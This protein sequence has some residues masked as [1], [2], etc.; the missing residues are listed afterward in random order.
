MP[1]FGLGQSLLATCDLGDEV[2]FDNFCMFPFLYLLSAKR[3]RKLH[4]LQESNESQASALEMATM[5]IIII[6]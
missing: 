3:I 4:K 5:F 6:V 2:K 1:F